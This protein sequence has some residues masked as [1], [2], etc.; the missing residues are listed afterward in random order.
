MALQIFDK[1][2]NLKQTI[3]ILPAA[4]FP[5]LTGNVTTSAGSLA[6]TVVG[7]S[8][9]FDISGASAGQIKFPATQNASA[10]ANTL[11][12]YQE[13]KAWTPSDGSGAGLVLTI[14]S[15]TYTKI[16]NV[17]I[18]QADIS[19]PSTANGSNARIS[20]LPFS[21]AQLTAGSFISLTGG[22][23]SP[24]T[25][26]NSNLIQMYNSASG[27]LLTNINLTLNRILLAG[28]YQV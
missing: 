27:A 9:L 18:F 25:I 7:A 20:G 23:T 24:G 17:I 26:I 14:N 22:L 1:A 11:D 13:K 6:T 10:D 15:A 28:S 16:G 8:G 21:A 19:Y 12:D 4:S 5:A 3:G 2:G